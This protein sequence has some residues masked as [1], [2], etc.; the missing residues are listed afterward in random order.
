MS[1]AVSSTQLHSLY[2]Y[3]MV[4]RY[5]NVSGWLRNYDAFTADVKKV[6]AELISG[7]DLRADSTY[8]GTMWEKKTPCWHAFADSLLRT[9]NDVSSKGQSVLSK[10]NFERF[11]ADPDFVEILCALI[12]SPDEHCFSALQAAWQARC[13]DLGA[14]RNQLLVNRV[15]AACTFDVC[16]TVSVEYLNVVYAWLAKRG[17]L[18][19]D[20][21][22]HDGW[23]ARNVHL[24]RQLTLA[25]SS[26]PHDE[27]PDALHLSV[28][29][30]QL[31]EYITNPFSL[32][33]QVIKYGSPGTGKTYSAQEDTK[34]QF[35]LWKDEF[36]GVGRYSYATCSETVQ[37]HPSFGY[38]DFMEGLRP[39]LGSDGKAHLLL[40][41]GVFKRL[42]IRAGAWERD[43]YALPDN[44]PA[45]AARWESLAIQ[46]I[47][48]YAAELPGEHWQFLLS[49]PDKKRRLAEAVPP[50]FIIIDEI[51]RAEL[52]R[53][54]G[55]L[56]YCLEY[57]GTA[58]AIS[59]QYS[60][61]NDSNT[62][63]LKVGDGFKFFV[64][65]NVYLIGTM[66]TVDRSVESFDLALRRRFRWEHVEPD[67]RV[68]RHELREHNPQ[69]I[70]LADNLGMLNKEISCTAA[71]GKDYQIGQ[72]Y[73]MNLRYPRALGVSQVRTRVWDDS[74]QPLLEEYLRGLGGSEATLGKFRTAFG[75]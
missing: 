32:K 64:P 40:T 31:Y 70:A 5:A 25:F 61:L 39:R 19:A 3:L 30:W 20:G 1:D 65:H 73:V 17:M 33:K 44:G 72:A 59:T 49:Y 57:R 36:G 18:G 34:W 50:F 42:C 68:L 56:M 22:R 23:Y 29:V 58:G 47:V 62:G 48:P 71:L 69:W 24:M 15:L 11:L 46:D 37:F 51:N 16:S 4:N 52:S 75:L 60:G 55:E 6:R 8:V 74:I 35:T 28:F 21:D 14:N 38:E 54:L 43:L 26:L 53:V 2:S 12:K 10:E 41:N 9:D 7:A 66:N 67:L 45:L 27:R 63:M 13:D